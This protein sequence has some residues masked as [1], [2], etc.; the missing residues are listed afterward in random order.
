MEKKKP[1][2]LENL[3]IQLAAEVTKSKARVKILEAP[4]EVPDD[5]G[6]T[7]KSK[8][9]NLDQLQKSKE[10]KGKSQQILLSGKGKNVIQTLNRERLMLGITE[11][12]LGCHLMQIES[13]V[14]KN[15]IQGVIKTLGIQMKMTSSSGRTPR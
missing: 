6:T 2:E 13:H 5:A 7:L 12:R 1:L 8:T 14:M 4:S 3:R 15:C 11:A 9:S 10:V